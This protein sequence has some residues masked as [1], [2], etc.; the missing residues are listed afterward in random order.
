M[1]RAIR[2]CLLVAI[3]LVSCVSASAL[4]QTSNA[5]P[6]AAALQSI[7]TSAPSESSASREAAKYP[8]IT[9]VNPSFFVLTDG[10]G[11]NT[12]AKPMLA[13]GIA[14]E[15]RK[16]MHT[17]PGV[18]PWIIPQP[19]W[20]AK[21][22]SDQC[23]DDPKA[24]GGVIITYYAGNASHFFLIYQEETLTFSLTAQVVACNFPV[25]AKDAAPTVVAVIAELPGAKGTP[26]VVRRSQVSVPLVSFAGLGSIFSKGTVS[27]KDNN[28]TSAAIV[29]GLFTQ[30]SSRD[31]PGYSEP[32]K[33]RYA[34]Q[35][36]GVDL[37]RAMRDTCAPLPTAPP[38]TDS[39]VL[40]NLCSYLGLTN[41]P[42]KV[43]E[44]Q[45]ALD[46]YEAKVRLEP[47]VP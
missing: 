33:M 21:D 23:H 4:G 6:P 45:R 1:K 17:L 18:Q 28:A 34:S 19:S 42:G 46:A 26:W 10:P 22:L 13:I 20:G 8:A 37:L 43:A 15:I 11:D 14:N 41:D 9:S 31:I 40:N 24:L 29:A 2:H 47:T 7:S 12:G 3:A 27:S 36:V 30:A 35:H 44:Q 25:G 32:L 38:L 39:S 5:V 16:A